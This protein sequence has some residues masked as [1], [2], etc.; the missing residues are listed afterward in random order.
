MPEES[1]SFEDALAALEARV[2]RLEGEEVSLEEAL[3][4]YEEGVGLAERCHQQLEAAE[5]RVAM[6]VRG[7]RGIE[8]QALTDIDDD[9]PHS[10]G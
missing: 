2:K 1:P 6:L 10:S 5:Q 4:L 9:G 8:E 7:E 3:T